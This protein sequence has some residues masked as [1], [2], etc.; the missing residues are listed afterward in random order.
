MLAAMMCI[1][2]FMVQQRKSAQ[3]AYLAD[4]VCAHLAMSIM[5]PDW[6][7]TLPESTEH[8]SLT[9][10]GKPSEQWVEKLLLILSHGLCHPSKGD[11]GELFVMLYFLFCGECL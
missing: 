11:V 7:I 3:I 2:H 6:G 1:Q 9:F 4:P 8:P 5:D 10:Q